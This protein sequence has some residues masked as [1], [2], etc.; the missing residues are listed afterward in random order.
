MDN[1]KWIE[2]AAEAFL[3]VLTGDPEGIVEELEEIF[4]DE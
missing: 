1:A 2:V 4:D 3:A